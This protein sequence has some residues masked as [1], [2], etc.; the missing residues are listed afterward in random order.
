MTDLAPTDDSTNK[1]E[2]RDERPEGLCKTCRN[3]CY[4]DWEI[5]LCSEYIYSPD[6]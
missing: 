2:D 5:V 6:N 4:S 1:E 3:T